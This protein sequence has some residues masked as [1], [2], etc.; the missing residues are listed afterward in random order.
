MGL[1]CVSFI[2]WEKFDNNLES[3]FLKIQK[4]LG[5]VCTICFENSKN[6]GEFFRK[7]GKLGKCLGNWPNHRNLFEKIRRIHKI[8]SENSDTFISEIFTKTH[9]AQKVSMNLST[10]GFNE[11]YQKNFKKVS[12]S[13]FILKRLFSKIPGEIERVPL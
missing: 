7:F 8:F 5:I 1:R 4:I 11:I 3:F 9:S 6:S 13:S 10:E 2:S 12:L